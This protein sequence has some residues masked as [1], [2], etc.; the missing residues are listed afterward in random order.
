MALSEQQ[1][2][3]ERY[4][5]DTLIQ[6]EQIGCVCVCVLGGGVLKSSRQRWYYSLI[7]DHKSMTRSAELQYSWVAAAGQGHWFAD[8]PPNVT[9]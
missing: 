6:G 9:M 8:F 7:A 1:A 4:V 2:Y 5:C 3:L